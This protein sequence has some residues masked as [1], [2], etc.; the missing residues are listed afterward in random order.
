MKISQKEFDAI[1]RGTGAVAEA[2]VAKALAPL[3]AKIA[4][5]E[6]QNAALTETVKSLRQEQSLA[7]MTPD[8]LR[9]RYAAL[10]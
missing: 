8:A 5:L 2:V 6:A 3:A 4:M 7:A 9:A 10:Q 1:V